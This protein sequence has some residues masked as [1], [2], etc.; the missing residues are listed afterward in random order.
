MMSTTVCLI[1][2]KVDTKLAPKITAVGAAP[3][4]CCIAREGEAA[5]RLEIL[6]AEFFDDRTLI[7]VYRERDRP[8]ERAAAAWRCVSPRTTTTDILSL[9][10]PTYLC[11]V[12]TSD[13]SYEAID[14]SEDVKYNSREALMTDL[15]QRLEHGQVWVHQTS[16]G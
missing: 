16:G 4:Q 7:A 11:T 3:F 15:V 13:L 5:V 6:D 2:I 8:G 14:A 1:E 12:N 10:G 9:T